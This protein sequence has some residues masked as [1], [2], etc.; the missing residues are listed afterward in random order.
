MFDFLTTD[1][2]IQRWLRVVLILLVS[3]I[4]ARIGRSVARLLLKSP[5]LMKSP[6]WKEGRMLALRSLIGG[7]VQLVILVIGFATALIQVGVSGSAIIT[8]LGLFSAAFGLSAQ[9]VISDYLSGMILIFEDQFSV[10]EKVEVNNVLGTVETVNLRATRIRSETGEIYLV[11]N[12]SVRLVRNLSRGQFSIATVRM[13]V[14]SDDLDKALALL[15]E[16]AKTAQEKLPDLI[17]EPYAL[18][19]TGSLARVVELTLIARTTYGKGAQ[20]RPQ[21]MALV[22]EAFRQAKINFVD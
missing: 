1:P 13:H 17:Q 21:L 19:E 9:P 7:A 11:P 14:S 2:L 12:G 6:R 3:F 18:C 15:T 16:I 5:R 4:L 20:T 10:G 8:A 22:A